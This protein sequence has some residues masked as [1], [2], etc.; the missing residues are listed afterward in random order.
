MLE[1]NATNVAVIAAQNV[2]LKS[3]VILCYIAQHKKQVL[4]H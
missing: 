1:H 3:L 2:E 4:K